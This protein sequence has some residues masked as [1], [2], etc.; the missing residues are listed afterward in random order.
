M[1][2]TL[3]QRFFELFDGL[4]CAHGI[5]GQIAEEPSREDGKRLGK[6][7]KTVFEPVTVELFQQHLDGKDGLGIIP[8][9]EDSS[10][11]FGAIDLDQYDGIDHTAIAKRI[12]NLK[13]PLLITKSKSGG[14]HFWLFAAEPVPAADMVA[15]LQEMASL[16]GYGTSEIFP[17]QIRRSG[18]DKD[19]GSWI[20]VAY[21]DGMMGGRFCVTADGNALNEDQFLTLANRR[22]QPIDFFGK[23]VSVTAELPQGPPCLQHLVQ[24]GLPQGTRNTVLHELALYAKKVDPEGFGDMVEDFNRKYMQPSL[25]AEEVRTIIFSIKKKDYQYSCSKQPMVQHCNAG[26]CRSRKYGVGKAKEQTLALGRLRKLTTEPPIWF[27]DVEGFSLKLMT[28]EIQNPALFQRVCMEQ[29]NKMPPVPKRTNWEEIVA[30]AMKD[31]DVIEIPDASRHAQF[32]E[33]L[34]GYLTGSAQ[35]QVREDLLRGVPFTEEGRTYFRLDALMRYLDIQRFK[36]MKRNDILS[37]LRDL[38]GR[39]D[40]LTLK[41]RQARYWSVP[42]F[43]IQTEGYDL[44]K[45]LTDDNKP[46]F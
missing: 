19:A 5:Y 21:Y 1:E 27:W 43:P 24:I 39:N 30:E 20:N 36:E 8:I 45:Q 12:D 2:K 41:G 28:D 17:K 34:I 3:A 32:T 44:P 23:A 42:V 10:A 14:C 38:G 18:H 6:I 37:S 4:K 9:R 29:L 13:L 33:I 26:L 31:L 40:S 7:R 11:C 22:K 35:G 46:T 25:P 15:R 16:L